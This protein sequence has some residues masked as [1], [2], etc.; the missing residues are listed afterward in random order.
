M[1]VPGGV[2]VMMMAM[3]RFL[4]R[5]HCVLG[6]G[7]LTDGEGVMVL[8]QVKRRH[9]QARPR[10]HQPKKGESRRNG[11]KPTHSI[12]ATS[13]VSIAT[14]AIQGFRERDALSAPEVRPL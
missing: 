11:S 4:Q 1:I 2:V 12:D 6:C 7:G 9:D 13:R 14:T 5:R 10:K 8:R 3:E